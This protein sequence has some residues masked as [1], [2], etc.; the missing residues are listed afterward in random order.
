VSEELL[1]KK[2]IKARKKIIKEK[3]SIP[4]LTSIATLGKDPV[5]EG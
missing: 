2:I 4:G 1:R 3:V 5:G